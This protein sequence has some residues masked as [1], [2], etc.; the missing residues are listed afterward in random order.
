MAAALDKDAVVAEFLKRLDVAKDKMSAHDGSGWSDLFTEDGVLVSLTGLV[1]TGKAELAKYYEER[2][3]MNQKSEPATLS[4]GA[5]VKKMG[6]KNFAVV[7]TFAMTE[8]RVYLQCSTYGHPIGSYIS[9]IMAG[10]LTS[11]GM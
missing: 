2:C 7:V 6:D 10:T 5:A 11:C 4:P 8:V 1:V 3:G 9:P